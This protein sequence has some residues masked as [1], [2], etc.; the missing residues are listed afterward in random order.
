MRMPMPSP[1]GTNRERLF[2]NSRRRGAAYDA[3]PE[4]RISQRMFDH[5]VGW[6][7]GKLGAKDS[8]EFA[9]LL[10]PH[11]RTGAD[12]EEAA[13]A[14]NTGPRDVAQ[15]AEDDTEG[16][17][18]ISDIHQFVRDRLQGDDVATF[19]TML[20]ELLRSMGD[21]AADALPTGSGG[22]GIPKNRIDL[23]R[24]AAD[25]RITMGTDSFGAGIDR[26]RVPMTSDR[27][28]KSDAAKYAPGIERITIGP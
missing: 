19:E 5:A 20:E 24:Q 27:K 10:Q 18:H 9:K 28:P 25:A 4:P 3:A 15:R 1:R 12:E 14:V 16:G 6:V 7:G 23:Q 22:T 11:V 2:V 17:D 21:A 8:A 26:G 13:E